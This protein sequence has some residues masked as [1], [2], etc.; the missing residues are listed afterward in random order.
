MHCLWT[1]QLKQYRRWKHPSLLQ[2]R[3]P[4]SRVIFTCCITCPL[5][6]SPRKDKSLSVGGLKIHFNFIF[7]SVLGWSEKQAKCWLISANIMTSFFMCSRLAGIRLKWPVSFLLF[8]QFKT[9]MW[10]VV[11][12]AFPGNIWNTFLLFNITGNSNTIYPKQAFEFGRQEMIIHLVNR[13]PAFPYFMKIRFFHELF[14][15]Y[16]CLLNNRN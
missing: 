5:S 7:S 16:N 12:I 15:A 10:H 9:M 14:S 1:G 6:P 13:Q 3:C 2:S 11:Q 4:G 8:P